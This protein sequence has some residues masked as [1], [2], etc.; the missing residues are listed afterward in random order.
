MKSSCRT[1]LLGLIV[2]SGLI[3]VEFI[4]D[5]PWCTASDQIVVAIAAVQYV[6][7][8]LTAQRIPVAA[9]EDEIITA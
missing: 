7:A 4:I 1:I 8:A 3:L 2:I 6:I 9:A 5:L